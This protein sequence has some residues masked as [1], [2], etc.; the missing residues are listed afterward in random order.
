MLEFSGTID[1]ETVTALVIVSMG[2]TGDFSAFLCIRGYGYAR[3]S[4]L[5]TGQA[6]ITG[7]SAGGNIT[8]SMGAEPGHLQ[9]HLLTLG[10]IT[11]DATNFG[12]VVD[13]TTITALEQ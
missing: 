7:G 11:I 8:V 3:W 2:S 1:A 13:A 12:G 4:C 5:T 10:S 6:T 9:W